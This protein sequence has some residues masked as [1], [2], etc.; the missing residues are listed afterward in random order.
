MAGVFTQYVYLAPDPNS[1]YRQ[2]SIRGRRI[3]ARTLY[4]L[5]VNSE[6]P[7]TAQAIASS[8]AA[9][10]R[11]YA[12]AIAYCRTDPPEIL[13]DFRQEEAMARATG[14]ND[15]DYRFHGRPRPLT[16]QARSQVDPLP[17]P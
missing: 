15:P 6:E 1:S 14:I 9:I 10:G 4:G 7:M 8:T 16:R 17:R 13:E 5:H 11:S 12:S 3:R 2:L